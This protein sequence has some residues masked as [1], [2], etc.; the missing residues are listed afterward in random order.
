MD[1][2]PRTVTHG[3]CL[4]RAEA[5]GYYL[6]RCFKWR[7][8]LRASGVDG[9]M[10]GTIVAIGWNARFVAA[11]RRAR[12]DHEDWMILDTQNERLQGPYTEEEWIA[13]RASD[14]SLA[15]IEVYKVDDAWA[16]LN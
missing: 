8:P 4:D 3:Y 6:T 5:G 7:D 1:R 9:P 15:G 10:Q 12:N 11:F 2:D 16:R 14:P 13:K